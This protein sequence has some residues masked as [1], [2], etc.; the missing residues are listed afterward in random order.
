MNLEL[1]KVKK[2]N[3]NLEYMAD[4]FA[5]NID[6]IKSFK[7]FLIEYLNRTIKDPDGYDNWNDMRMV[8]YNSL[9]VYCAERYH[10]N[11]L[12]KLRQIKYN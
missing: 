2:I 11:I 12:E 6:R 3:I 5:A 7:E 1:K 9:Y 4:S 8:V 10:S